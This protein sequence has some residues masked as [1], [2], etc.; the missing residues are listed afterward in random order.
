MRAAIR[1]I[2]VIA[3][4]AAV[5]L[6]VVSAGALAAEADAPPPLLGHYITDTRAL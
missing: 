6:S 3:V 5:A 1:R 2:A 4:I